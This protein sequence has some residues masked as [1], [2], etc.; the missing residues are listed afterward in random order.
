[1]TSSAAPGRAARGALRLSATAGRVGVRAAGPTYWPAE[2]AR[3]KE[4]IAALRELGAGAGHGQAAGGRH[5][6][7]HGHALGHHGETVLGLAAAGRR[8]RRLGGMAASPGVAEGVAR[9]VVRADGHRRHPGGRGPGRAASPRPAGR[10]CSAKIAATVTDIGGMM[11]H[12]AIVCRE[13]GLPAVT[14]TASAQ[15]RSRP[16]SGCAWTATTARSPSWMTDHGPVGRRR[17]RTCGRARTTFTSPWPMTTRSGWWR[18]IRTSTARSCRW[19]SC[20]TT[21]AGRSSTRRRSTAR[22]LAPT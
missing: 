17:A 10:R 14:G 19:P 9:V 2:M 16:A 12:A 20:C 8:R 6:A 1:M 5:R 18:R 21:S 4:I 15:P 11:S 7:V 22:D 3:R 13:Y